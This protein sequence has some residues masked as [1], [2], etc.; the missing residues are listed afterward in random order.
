MLLIYDVRPQAFLVLKYSRCYP[1]LK[2]FFESLV[3]FCY[4]GFPALTNKIQPP[5]TIMYGMRRIFCG[6]KLKYDGLD[7]S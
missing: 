7:I 6:L 5:N 2:H 1:Q 3:V 4:R